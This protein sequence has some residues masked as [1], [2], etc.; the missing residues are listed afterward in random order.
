MKINGPRTN[1]GNVLETKYLL[2]G[3]FLT[4]IWCVLVW[5]QSVTFNI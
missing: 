1:A 4:D 5:Y 2:L 3:L